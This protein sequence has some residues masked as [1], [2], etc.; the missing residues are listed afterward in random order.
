MVTVTDNEKPQITCPAVAN[1]CYNST[2]TYTINETT[3]GDNCGI[4]NVTYSITG[5]TSRTGS[6]T[7]A[8][9]TF[10]PGSST[11]TWTV[12]DVNGNSNTCQNTV[13]VDNPFNVTI[14]D[15]YAVN[16]GADVNTVYLGYA[17]ASSVKLAAKPA[18]GTGTFTYLWST[19]S[20][21]S[22]ITVS[23]TAATTYT[24]TVK[25]G[26][27]CTA[28]TTKTIN[29]VDV[30]CG[31]KNDMVLICAGGTPKCIKSNTVTSQLNSGAYL[32]PCKTA[33][34][35]TTRSAGENDLS[36]NPT[37]LSAL[38][39]PTHTFFTIITGDLGMSSNTTLIVR[40]S[41]GMIVEKKELTPHQAIQFGSTYRPGV[42]M[43]ELIRGKE[44]TI[45]KLIKLND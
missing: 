2:N 17:P 19:G 8:S 1:L 36:I 25:D 39:N 4:Q 31:A 16:K 7:N 23:P 37:G 35:S 10:N 43:A 21:S 18:G 40:N 5:A 20:T 28:T 6:G 12:K 14:P 32:G 9:G 42:Y 33:V 38:P 11:I 44:R 24:V 13:T 26:M 34:T 45:Q 3:T 22:S 29:V 15:V 30:R 41:L 27:G